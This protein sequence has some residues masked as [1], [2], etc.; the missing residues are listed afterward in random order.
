MIGECLHLGISCRANL[1]RRVFVTLLACIAVSSAMP[2]HHPRYH[3]CHSSYGRHYGCVTRTCTFKEMQTFSFRLRIENE[4]AK[5]FC[6]LY[7]CIESNTQSLFLR[8]IS[9]TLCVLPLYS[10]FPLSFLPTSVHVMRRHQNLVFPKETSEQTATHALTL[11]AWMDT[12]AHVY[13][14]TLPP[15]HLANQNPLTFP[16]HSSLSELLESVFFVRGGLRR[17]TCAW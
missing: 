14:H 5:T 11:D 16:Q 15:H 2:S 1:C 8:T 17:Q 12:P 10:L 13:S 3:N 6:C 4:N 9:Y 7:A